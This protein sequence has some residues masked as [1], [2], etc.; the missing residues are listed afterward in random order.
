MLCQD[1]KMLTHLYFWGASNSSAGPQIQLL[2]NLCNLLLYS[3]CVYFAVGRWSRHWGHSCCSPLHNPTG[4]IQLN[5][6]SIFVV[7][8]DGIVVRSLPRLADA[9]LL[10]F[11]LIYALHL[12]YPKKLIHTFT[13]VQ[14]TLLC[15]DDNRPLKPCLSLKNELFSNVEGPCV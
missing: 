4:T 13:F 12:D 11:G 10:L 7:I 8:E 14:K 2:N 6:D 9:L 15:L 3:V 1:K 5:P